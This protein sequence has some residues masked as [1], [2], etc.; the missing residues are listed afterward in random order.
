MPIKG[1]GVLFVRP[2]RMH[3]V[4]NWIGIL[5]WKYSARATFANVGVFSQQQSF[6]GVFQHKRTDGEPL[7]LS[8]KSVSASSGGYQ[9]WIAWSF[10]QI[11]S[12]PCCPCIEHVYITIFLNL[13][14]RLIRLES[15]DDKVIWEK[16][17][18]ELRWISKSS[19]W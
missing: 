2:V 9:I 10:C 4:E 12:I 11:E 6:A 18:G 8:K 14:N 1:D 5:D 15:L 13:A 3:S 19:N 17:K 16:D 7:F